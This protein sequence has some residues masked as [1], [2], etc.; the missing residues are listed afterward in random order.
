MSDEPEE[1]IDL[2][3]IPRP[4]PEGGSINKQELLEKRDLIQKAYEQ[5]APN[6]F[7][8]F[9]RGLYIAS[10]DGA[11]RAEIFENV[12]AGF[13]RLFFDGVA[14][15]I[16]AL[17]DGEMP[18]CRRFWMER[19]KKASKDADLAIVLL[20]LIA[21]PRRPFYA[22]VGAGN[23]DQAGIVK[24]RMTVLLHWNPWLNNYIEINRMQ[25]R[26]KAK[27]QDGSPMATLDILSADASGAHGGTPD[28]LVINELSHVQKFEF[29]E[30]LMDNADGVARGIVMVATN[31]GF[32]GSP[33]HTWRENAIKNEV[34]QTYVYARPAPWHSRETIE[35]AKRRNSASRY[36]R[37]WKG[38]WVSGVGDAVSEEQIYK[39][40]TLPGP[41]QYPEDGWF[42]IAGLDIG[43]KHDHCGFT[44]IGVNPQAQIARIA[45][46]KAW[47]PKV[48][49]NNE[50][51]L[52]D[53]ESTVEL[54]CKRFRVYT[55]IFDPHQAALM[56]QRL[57]KAGLNVKEMT[58]SSPSNCTAMATSFIQ[59]M[60]ATKLL[61]YD[62]DEARLKRDFAK[63]Q[64]VEKR[65]GY[66]LEATSDA[67]GHA[68]VGTAVL[69]CLP[70]VVEYLQGVGGID[71]D[72]ELI[73]VEPSKKM[74]AEEI[75]RLPDEYKKLFEN[76]ASGSADHDAD[77]GM[78]AERFF[79]EI[80]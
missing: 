19:T 68:D 73:N 32:V 42:Y 49:Q 6:N 74:T 45:W 54:A 65:T 80:E 66:K 25:V 50:V 37:L 8:G 10:Q 23:R 18:K 52:I 16:H 20:W 14:S 78:T 30:T 62:D 70:S 53:V 26:S 43:V 61:C 15:S 55:L 34:W 60:M 17:R 77:D 5:M 64:I 44:I 36:Q 28:L 2:S 41:L 71:P 4:S 58:F 46:W 13:Q 75:R 51:D 27:M 72:V 7:M 1:K 76:D 39:A 57:T 48:S 22:Q 9:L 3:Q 33:A 12:M 79:S 56:A 63:F 47:D 69:M 29:A 38:R 31:A 35:D 24:S 67:F 59:I 40:F 11:S 21:F